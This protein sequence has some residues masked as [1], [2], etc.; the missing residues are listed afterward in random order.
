MAWGAYGTEGQAKG[1]TVIDLNE[2]E[3]SSALPSP[4]PGMVMVPMRSGTIQS[5]VS[6][7]RAARKRKDSYWA[8]DRAIKLLIG[9]QYSGVDG[10]APAIN[11]LIEE[12]RR[13]KV[14]E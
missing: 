13:L 2:L 11:I 6:E 9:K 5:V 3:S 4:I 10:L 7:L 8:F 12:M 1:G 14:E